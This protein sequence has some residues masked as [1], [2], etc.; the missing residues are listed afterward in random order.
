MLSRSPKGD[1]SGLSK[2]RRANV[3]SISVKHSRLSSP[4]SASCVWA[5]SNADSVS[6]SL[7][8]SIKCCCCKRGGE[9]QAVNVEVQVL[10]RITIFSYLNRKEA[11]L[12]TMT[13]C[14]GFLPT[15]NGGG[16]MFILIL[17]VLTTLQ[18]CC[19]ALISLKWRSVVHLESL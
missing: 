11:E 18:Y 7:I 14:C 8:N 16:F 2:A 17:A 12:C 9:A 6:L 15:G 1:S 3:L 13:V 5:N 4:C 10:Y 19:C